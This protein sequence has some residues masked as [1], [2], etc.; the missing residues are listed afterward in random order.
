MI[1]MPTTQ[2][3]INP[4][5]RTLVQPNEL[6]LH[7]ILNAVIV[8]E[9]FSDGLRAR[10][11]LQQVCTLPNQNLS[12][13]VL[14]W[15]F[16]NLYHR[17]ESETDFAPANGA[18]LVIVSIERNHPLPHHVKTWIERCVA[19]NPSGPSFLACLHGESYP[20]TLSLTPCLRQIAAKW[21]LPSASWGEPDSSTDI[22]LP[23]NLLCEKHIPKKNFPNP[24][25]RPLHAHFDAGGINE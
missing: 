16:A 11:L 12:V 6:A 20:P 17:S 1:A 25:F 19:D 4:R 7:L 22:E 8:Y 5:L 18:H 9:T 21:D 2:V 13:N 23:I 15:S 24:P 3:D 14:A 10:E